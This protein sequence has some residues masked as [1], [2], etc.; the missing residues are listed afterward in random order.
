MGGDGVWRGGGLANEGGDD[1][2][3]EVR[4]EDKVRGLV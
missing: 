2:E 3:V 1:G 4:S